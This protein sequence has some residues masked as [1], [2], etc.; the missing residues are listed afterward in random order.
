[1]AILTLSLYYSIFSS[2]TKR[3]YTYYMHLKY[4]LAYEGQI[5]KY[6]QEFGL[7]PSLVSA[8]IY[9][10]SRFNPYS[11]SSRGAIGL[12]QLLPDTAEYISVKLKDKAFNPYK[13]SD[14]DQNIRYGSYYLKYLNDK[15]RDTDKVL[16]AYNAGEGNVDRW[17]SEGDYQVKFAETRNFVERVEKSK[18]IYQ[19]LYFK[20]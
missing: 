19:N 15:Y 2:V 10:E 12:M 16:A 1:M 7:D 13:I 20:K 5:D 14:V 11:G 4:P 3:V 18:L 9:E 17:I 6:S 8:V